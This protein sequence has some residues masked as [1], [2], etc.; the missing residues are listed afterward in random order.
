MS[1]SLGAIGKEYSVNGAMEVI[2]IKNE[3]V[4]TETIAGLL[5]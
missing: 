4:R 5:V 3:L 1:V 2:C